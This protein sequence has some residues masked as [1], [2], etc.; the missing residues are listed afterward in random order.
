[1]NL[2]P[3][4]IKQIKSIAKK[5]GVSYLY[6]FG[7]QVR[8]QGGPLSDFDFAV[9]FS[10]RVKDK[11]KNK[12]DLQ[13]ELC[14][15]LQTNKVDVVDIEKADPILAFNIV[16]EGK[17]IYLKN[18]QETILDK[19]KIFSIYLDKKYY[20]DRHFKIAVNQ[21]AAGKI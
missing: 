15:I 10:P 20:Y 3:T 1:M 6:L 11:F 9:K 16:A 4:Q 5:A 2:K 7:S 8:G 18:K 12:L 21:M 17:I 19:A 14:G 13:Q